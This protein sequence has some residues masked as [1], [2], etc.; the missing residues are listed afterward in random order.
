VYSDADRKALHVRYADEAYAVGPAPSSQS[1]LRVDRVLEAARRSGAEAVHPGYGFLSENEEFAR[2]CEAAGI[3]FIGPT[4]G[5]I[6]LM[7][8][9]TASRRALLR[10][11]L[12]V[13]PGTDRN[14]ESLDE[15]RH[16][17]GEIGYPVMLKASAGGGGKGMRLVNS[18]LELESALR[19][20][21]SEAQN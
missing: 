5:T 7:G 19:N 15:A 12:P 10:A 17:A 4:A 3:V 16:I 8:S 2:A 18:P 13:V 6:E 14:L 1:Y 20:A 11:G 21:R 9:K